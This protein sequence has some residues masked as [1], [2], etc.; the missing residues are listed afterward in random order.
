MI[1]KFLLSLII[2]FLL[3]GCFDN[4]LDIEK[5]EGNVTITF[6]SINQGRT[7]LPDAIDSL[8]AFSSIE[9]TFSGGPGDPKT[10]E[11]LNPGVSAACN[12]T[13]AEGDW[14]V[15][16]KGFTTIAGK[17]YEAARGSTEEPIS[18]TA[19]G[20]TGSISLQTGIFE[21]APGVFT[22]SITIPASVSLSS[23]NLKIIPFEEYL[24]NT[25]A[26]ETT[27]PLTTTAGST[28]SGSTDLEPGNYYLIAKGTTAT[29]T[30]ATWAELVYIYSG[31]ETVAEKVFVQD[32]FT[33]TSRTLGG[34]ASITGTYRI[35]ETLNAVT[36][37]IT[38]VGTGAVFNYQWRAG[39]TNIAGA[40]NATYT[41][42][43]ADAGSQITCVIT[44]TNAS[45]TITATGSTVPFNI[46]I[47]MAG[48]TGADSLTANPAFGTVG[49]NITLSYTLANTQANNRLVFS[50]VAAAISEV[51]IAET[52]TRSY[53]VAAA[54]ATNGVI[55][56]TGTF[57]HAALQNDTI[58][59]ANTNNE[60]RTYGDA[61]FTKAITTTGSGTGAITYASSNTTVATV[62][63]AGLVTILAAGTTTITAT[64]ASD[65]SYAQ[66]TA[67]YTLTVNRK[68]VTIT[69]L[70]VQDKVYNRNTNAT[71]TGTPAVS[72]VVGTDTVTVVNGTAAFATNTAA[73]NKTVIFTGYSL[74]GTHAGN[75]ILS[76]Q[77]V[78]VTANI[79]RLQL[80]ATNPTYTATKTYNANTAL[81]GTTT[82][83]TLQ[84]VIPGDTVTRTVAGSYDNATVGT[85][86]TIT[87]VYT[88]AGLSNANYIA[89]VNFTATNGVINRATGA[90]IS[91]V[92]TMASR[93]TTS[94]T[95]NAATLNNHA[96]LGNTGQTINYA[97]TTSTS[98]IAPTT[99]WQAGLTFTGLNPD[100]TYYVWARSVQSTNF[101]QG[102]ASRSAAITTL[103]PSAGINITVTDGVTN[104]PVSFT[105]ST[106]APMNANESRT[107]TVSGTY[108]SYM[109]M[110]NGVPVQGAAAN[111]LTIRGVDYTPGDHQ[112]LV[113]VYSD[114][115]PFSQ[116]IYFT[117]NN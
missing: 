23:G 93:T 43:G 88:I 14:N 83:G 22:Y 4:P 45:G 69:G 29:D 20:G 76:A 91:N 58:A 104:Q 101:A 3:G 60:T 54:D 13:L 64:K 103:L 96:Q 17:K 92:A 47:A 56:I 105:N 44:H 63:S 75:Y 57:S 71:V 16:A 87:F 42:T 68:P 73:N 52:G 18:V 116:F 72:G 112:I 94:I 30:T 67:S 6:G 99:G 10:V 1:K 35:G 74:G 32:D 102:T 59:F 66:A 55:T 65:G 98:M 110:V 19:T 41:I 78:S 111:S 90:T 77:P 9:L 21:G 108:T 48:N 86:K 79:T 50:G 7:I 81:A 2:V 15:D 36:T 31:K 70:S 89:P 12:T 114:D 82:A 46:N 106:I 40:N 11:I 84:G 109:W 100:T 28:T 117:V 95:V 51:T 24:E 115:I 107:I 113:I 62:S 49:T 27:I 80:T 53:T 37:S 38:G 85:G 39:E 8:S 61:A 33:V 97:I 5:A 26:T 34:T 25:A